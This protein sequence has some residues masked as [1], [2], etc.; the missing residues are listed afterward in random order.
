MK[1][2]KVN[3]NQIRCILTAEDLAERQLRLGELAYGSEKARKLFR[4]MMQQAAYQFGFDVE[5]IPLMIEAIPLSAESIALIVT[6][7]ENPE[8]LDTRFSNFGPSIQNSGRENDS[9]ALTPIEQLLSAVR[10]GASIQDAAAQEAS[11]EG[12]ES[13]EVA[14]L[15]LYM[16]T[17]RLY[18]FDSLSDAVDAARAAGPAFDGE[19]ALYHDPEQDLYCLFLSLRDAEHVRQRQDVLAALTEFGR[20]EPASTAREEHLKEHCRILIASGALGQL[21]RIG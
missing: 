9:S 19:S 15:R 10:R 6:K 20:P 17:H 7:V 5:N 3:D 12:G 8:E 1:I 11:S 16:M 4:D 2:E 13:D 18:L 14:R 21:A